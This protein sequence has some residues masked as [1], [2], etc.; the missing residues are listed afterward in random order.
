MAIAA[1]EINFDLS[2]YRVREIMLRI[3]FAKQIF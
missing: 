3:N 2:Q 1:K